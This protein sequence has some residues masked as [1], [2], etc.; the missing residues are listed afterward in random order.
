[1]ALCTCVMAWAGNKPIAPVPFQSNEYAPA[2]KAAAPIRMAK[3]D[4]VEQDV[5]LEYEGFSQH[6]T[7][8]QAAFNALPENSTP[9]TV[10]LYSDVDID[11]EGSCLKVKAFQRVTLDLNGHGIYG[12]TDEATASVVIEN[13]G[14]LTINDK[15]GTGIITNLSGNP[16]VSWS[17]EDEEHPYPTY[18]NN[19]INNRGNGVLT[20]NGGLIKNETA[21]AAAYPIDMYDNSTLI[22]NGGHIYNYFTNAIRFFGSSNMDHQQNVTINDGLI[23]GYSAIWMQMPSA[24]VAP[25]MN[26]TINGGEIKTT[27]KKYQTGEITIYQTSDY[28]YDWGDGNSDNISVNITGGTFNINLAVA[29]KA[30]TQ[31]NISGGRFNG[32]VRIVNQNKSVVNGGVFDLTRFYSDVYTGYQPNIASGYVWKYVGSTENENP[33]DDELYEVVPAGQAVINKDTLDANNNEYE[34][35]DIEQHLDE[36][37]TLEGTIVSIVGA[38]GAAAESG[39]TVKVTVNTGDVVEVNGISGAAEGQLVVKDGATLVI[40]NGGIVS[41]ND[42]LTQIVVEA[43]GTVAVGT[44]GV[45]KQG[46]ATPIEI[47][48]DGDKSGVLLIDPNAPA[49]V[50]EALAKV[51]VYT[52]AHKD[53]GME[54]WQQFASPV[55]GNT[56]KVTPLGELQGN[57]NFMT[58]LYSWDYATDSWV[59]VT[60]GMEEISEGVY[61]F[62]GDVV[63]TTSDAVLKPFAAYDLINN[64]HDY[65]GGVTYEFAG[66][67]V[68]NGDMV[69]SFPENGFCTFGNSYTAPIDLESFFETVKNDIQ[70]DYDNNN[71]LIATS[72]IDPCVYIFNSA[73]NCFESVNQAAIKLWKKG[74]KTPAFTQIPPQ[75]AFV[76]NLL[77]GNSGQSAVNYAASVWGNPNANQNV[78]IKA[79]KRA[80]ETSTLSALLEITVTDGNA[81]DRVMLIED[82]E[83]S[84]EYDFGADAVKYMNGSFNLYANTTIGQLDMV[85]TDNIE[86]TELSFKAG[87]AVN[88]TISFNNV[89][90]DFVLIDHANNSQVAI[91]EGGIYTFA[92]QPNVTAEN[93]FAIVPAAKMPTAIENTEVK[94]NVKGI[95]TIMGQYLGEDFDVLPAGVYV[96]DGVK[97]VK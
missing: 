92:T 68:G 79:P 96:I 88:Y 85:A 1:M 62:R 46:D 50:A 24:N 13:R 34:L 97:I 94:A 51:V 26:L 72:A 14:N 44:G 95:Y 35:K 45:N 73:K 60:D 17:A 30:G 48:S 87:N 27:T 36:G 8:L 31:V 16:D 54:Y 80:E 77:K 18:A 69:L 38:G 55:K 7:S 56:I 76:M 3:A 91:E 86:N 19:V 61:A 32:Y 65:H 37:E 40:G 2:Q 33:L 67:L 90:G 53:N 81:T 59:R 25:K 11:Y 74:I 70:Y 52:R 21:G 10:T 43:G 22:I 66:E 12:T 71:N 63:W 6:F 20:I 57:H 89:E 82:E 42:T 83:Y 29:W 78:P 75:Q 93:R 15:V 5:L 64:S 49:E 58:S 41:T 39:D 28:I 23:E 4:A 9:A 47:Q 84:N